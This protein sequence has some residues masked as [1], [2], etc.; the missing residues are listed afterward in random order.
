M[1]GPRVHQPTCSHAM[2]E[3]TD[4]TLGE[5]QARSV[6][7]PF[8][9]ETVYCLLWTSGPQTVLPALAFKVPG[10]STL[11]GSSGTCH[12]AKLPLGVSRVSLQR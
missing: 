4:E 5:W 3:H 1:D 9:S 11:S 6:F 12:H 2:A 10:L 7:T 8:P